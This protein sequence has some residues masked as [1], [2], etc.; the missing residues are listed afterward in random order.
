MKQ[1]IGAILS[2]ILGTALIAVGVTGTGSTVG[3]AVTF[4]GLV[5]VGGVS[6]ACPTGHITITKNVVG[7]G[8]A[9]A[10]GWKF[11]ITSDNCAIFPGS[12]DT[13][14]IPAAGG[15][16]KSD[17]LFATENV[18]NGETGPQ[19]NYTVT[20][21]AVAGWTTTYAPTGV[22]HLG[23]AN[24]DGNNDVALTVTNTATPG[25]TTPPPTTPSA[26]ASPT[27]GLVNTGAKHV[28]PALFVGI[29]LVLLGVVL[30]FFTRKPRRAEH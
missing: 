30:L 8:T 14:T 2:I 20:E 27:T 29:G 23:T 26:S 16:Q 17:R 22:I 9:P 4:C 19:C 24:T 1:R 18:S 3:A 5:E 15:V 21:T 13:V 12:S 10:A 25:T 6:P 11:T 28:K 7:T